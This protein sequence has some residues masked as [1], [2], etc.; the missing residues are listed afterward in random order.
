MDVMTGQD[1]PYEDRMKVTHVKIEQQNITSLSF[2]FSDHQRVVA[3]KSMSPSDDTKMTCNRDMVK[4]VQE[5]LETKGEAVHGEVDIT[6]EF[7]VAEDGSLM[8]HATY[9][10]TDKYFFSLLRRKYSEEYIIKYPRC[11]R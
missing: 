5:H 8:L 3:A 11:D 2:A 4:I 1:L 7:S 6:K 10:G 9:N